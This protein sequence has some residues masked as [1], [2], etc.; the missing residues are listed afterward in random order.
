MVCERSKCH[1]FGELLSRV[2]PERCDLNSSVFLCINPAVI[3]AAM[4]VATRNI[5][6]IKWVEYLPVGC[7]AL[8][9]GF[10]I[11]IATVQVPWTWCPLAGVIFYREI[12]GPKFW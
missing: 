9:K 6:R 3:P 4:I 10:S 2:I 1:H 8:F 12:S 5:K 11:H 7:L